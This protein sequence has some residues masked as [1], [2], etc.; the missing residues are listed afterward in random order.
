MTLSGSWRGP[1]GAPPPVQVESQGA[2]EVA[3]GSGWGSLVGEVPPSAVAPGGEE[4]VVRPRV[5]G[6]G[7]Q[8]SSAGVG[9]TPPA[10]M[11]APPFPPTS[12]GAEGGAPLPENI[13]RGSPEANLLSALKGGRS[14]AQ[15]AGSRAPLDHL[16][17]RFGAQNF[18]APPADQ[19]RTQGSAWTR[20]TG[21]PER[22]RRNVVQLRYE[23]PDPCPARGEVVDL[24][25]SLGFGVGD[26]FAVIHPT[27]TREFDISFVTPVCMERFITSF[28]LVRGVDPWKKYRLIPIS[29]QEEVKNITILV[30]NESLPPEDIATWLGRYGQLQTPL[31]K[32]LDERGV[33]TGA[34][35]ARIRLKRE[36]NSV[37]HL[38]GSAFLGRDRILAF[39]P[40]Q[41]RRC[42]KCG[43]PTHMSSD[44]TVV[45]CGRCHEF[46]HL[47]ESCGKICCNLC[48]EMGHPF[49]RCPKAYRGSSSGGGPPGPGA[50]EAPPASDGRGGGDPG[51]P[52][53]P[54]EGPTGPQP[55]RRRSR[56]GRGA[57]P[58]GDTGSVG[59]EAP[60][61]PEG[62]AGGEESG[63]PGGPGPEG[64]GPR[65]SP[66]LVAGPIPPLHLFYLPPH[67]APPHL[68]IP[69]PPPF[70]PP[71]PSPVPPSP[72][73]SQG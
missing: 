49:S 12:G 17:S 55:Q 26:L 34:W 10:G 65:L 9:A 36:G 64:P 45:R 69:V 37:A 47:S 8:G 53:A 4:P 20:G 21:G 5:V 59:Q 3:E 18:R 7:G 13:F 42:F 11:G 57:P 24:V 51:A 68:P 63:R 30:R 72:F 66:P 48:G 35:L 60:D 40:G 61:P 29:R 23:G 39:Y 41:P 50:A 16:Y 19:E 33:W 43:S 28:G 67:A 46:G 6:Q 32:N 2:G 15:V 62:E 1:R 73:F 25:L 22:R 54:S 71:L 44:C 52:N 38:P 27:N 70:V 14:F 31:R 56:R 58:P